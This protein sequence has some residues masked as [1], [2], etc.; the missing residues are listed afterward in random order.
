MDIEK[1]F[2]VLRFGGELFQGQ[3]QSLVRNMGDR[4]LE[5]IHEE[6]QLGKEHGQCSEDQLRSLRQELLN[7]YQ[8]ELERLNS[9]LSH[10]QSEQ[11]ESLKEGLTG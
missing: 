3:L 5:L 10:E 4:A 1:E 11:L 7:L 2:Y 9:L 8:K 6:C